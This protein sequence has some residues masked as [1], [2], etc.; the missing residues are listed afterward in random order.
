M[1][2]GLALGLTAVAVI[3]GLIGYKTVWEPRR[4][5]QLERQHFRSKVN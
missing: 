5:R 2:L 1:V 3:G 4:R